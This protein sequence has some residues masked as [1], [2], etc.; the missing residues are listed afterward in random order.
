MM[1]IG[2]VAVIAMLWLASGDVGEITAGSAYCPFR[3][4]C[5][6]GV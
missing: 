4:L 6:G 1:L 5:A 2:G 3:L